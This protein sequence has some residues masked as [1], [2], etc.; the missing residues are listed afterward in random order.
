MKNKLKLYRKNIYNAR[1]RE[2]YI[3]ICDKRRN[4]GKVKIEK[5]RIEAGMRVL[6][7]QERI[8][9]GKRIKTEK[10]TD[11][12]EK[13][14]KI[15]KSRSKEYKKLMLEREPKYLLQKGRCNEWKANRY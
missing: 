14:N 4:K 1:T 13:R 12:E 7:F 9:N 8:K 15:E 5:V 10:M 3:R 2:K 11:K 6:K